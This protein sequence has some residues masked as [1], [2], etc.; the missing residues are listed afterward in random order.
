[1][2]GACVPEGRPSGRVCLASSPRPLIVLVL[3]LET[4]PRFRDPWVE[5]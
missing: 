4:R 5:G 3:V 1:M 2:D